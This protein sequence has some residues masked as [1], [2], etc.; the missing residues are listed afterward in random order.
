MKKSSIG[1]TNYRV[2]ASAFNGSHQPKCIACSTSIVHN[3]TNADVD[4]IHK[5][6][7]IHIISDNSLSKVE[8]KMLQQ[9]YDSKLTMNYPQAELLRWHHCL[10]HAHFKTIQLL[11]AANILHRSL[12][13]AII[14]KCAA[15][16]YGTLTICPWRGKNVPNKIKPTI[17]HG[18]GDCVSVDQM[19]SLLPGFTAQMKG[20]LTKRIYNYTTVFVDHH[21]RLQYVYL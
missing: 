1:A 18:L 14:P 4:P 17:V 20:Q 13:N 6:N 8:L 12:V 16:Q 9:S 11:A 10:V 7:M 19:G 2:F 15:C 5:Q 21:S 3:T